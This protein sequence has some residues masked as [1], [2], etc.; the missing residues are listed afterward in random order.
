M[1]ESIYVPEIGQMAHGQPWQRHDLPDWIEAFLALIDQELCRVMGNRTQEAYDSPFANTGNRFKNDTFAI[2][3]YSW[4]D[5]VEQ[6]WNFKWGDIEVSW[7]K[8]AFRGA[9][10]N[11]IPSFDE[12]VQMLSACLAS[13][14]A[15]DRDDERHLT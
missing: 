8:W 12:G 3:A 2:E 7:Y 10:I 15:M 11:R 4:N 14:R 13:L 5:D 9:S 6:P 1:S